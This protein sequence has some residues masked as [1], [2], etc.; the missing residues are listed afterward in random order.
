MG[1]LNE[2][3]DKLLAGSTTKQLV[4]QGYAKSSVFRVAKKTKNPQPD[5]V[6]LPVPN[7]IQELRHRREVIKLQKEIAEL[8]VAKEKVPDRLAK[9]ETDVHQLNQQ[10]PDLVANCYASLYMI[11]LCKHG[12]NEDEALQKAKSIGDDFLKC[13]G[14]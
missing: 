6:T 10:L 8:E 14:Y 13:F 2:I 5:A 4:K 11:I 3:R 1:K 7:E 9:L 12:W